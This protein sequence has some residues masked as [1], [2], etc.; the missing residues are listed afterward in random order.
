VRRLRVLHTVG[1]LELGGGQKLTALVARSLDPDRFE[2]VVLSFGSGGAYAAQLR[3][4]GI[5]VRELGLRRPLRSNSIHVLLRA[6]ARLLATVLRG[7]WDVVH[8]HMFASAVIVTPLARLGGARAL[9]TAHRI[10]Y[11]R[12]QARVE[13]AIAHLQSAIVVDS[14]AVK[15]ILREQ[16][17]IPDEKYVV[18]H[19]GIDIAEFTVLPAIEDARAVLGVSRDAV[20]VSEIA[21][22]APHKGQTHLI[23]AVRQVRERHPA[24]HLLLVGDGPSRHELETLVQQVGLSDIV[25]LTGAR[26]DLATV[27]AATDVLALPS[28]FE[29]FGIVQAEAMYLRR[30]VVATS[31][32]GATEVVVD[33]ETG[34]LVPFGDVEALADR[35]DRLVGNPTL[36]SEMGAAGRRR[37]EAHFTR[38]IMGVAYA[39]LYLDAGR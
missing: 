7:R 20:V 37:V 19:N 3:A 17:C 13:R 18:I 5:E 23:E 9:G 22:L 35:L 11:G 12:F 21:H 32:G 2:V 24:V 27:L 16:T 14:H 29:G 31:R 8:T 4:E 15:E 39:H 34:F 33:E 1:N 36:R 38:E 26:S 28:T 30:P 10:Y 6:A 25:T